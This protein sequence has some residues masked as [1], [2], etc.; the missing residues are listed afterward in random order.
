MSEC[1]KFG[2]G[3]LCSFCKN[4]YAKIF[5]MLSSHRISTNFL[6]DLNQN[7]EKVWQSIG[8][9]A[10]VFFEN[11]PNIINMLWHFEVS[12][13][14]G[15]KFKTLLLQFST[16]FSQSLWGHFA[17]HGG[18]QAIS[19]LGHALKNMALE[20]SHGNHWENHKIC[21]SLKTAVSRTK[22]MKFCDSRCKRQRT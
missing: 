2:W 8:I 17:Y 6:P 5:K 12:G 10:I 1:F 15:C 7:L 20:I 21:N 18:M 22:W 16:N 3:S 14:M 19:Y 13:S 4:S 9:Q 11:L